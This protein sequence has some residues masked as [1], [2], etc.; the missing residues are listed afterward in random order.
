MRST[1][2]VT[3]S[4]L[5]ALAACGS[6]DPQPTQGTVNPTS[7]RGSIDGVDQVVAAMASGDATS[8]AGGVMALTAAGQSVLVPASASATPRLGELPSHWGRPIAQSFTGSATCTATSCTFTDFGDDSQYGS[9]RLNG[10]ITRSGNHLAFDL[11]FDVTT[12]TVTGHWELD[13]ALDITPTSI[14]GDVHGHGSVSATT[15]QGNCS[16]TWDVDV[17]YDSIGLD[18]SGC[19]TSGSLSASVSYTA[20]SAQGGGSF[21]AAGTI[22]FGPSCGQIH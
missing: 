12:A 16:A 22:A 20:N 2:F 10:S 11:A 3:T 21:N 9:Y 7:A 6:D 17:A 18:G 15:Q 14:D 8:A 4:I 19:P 1:S 13:G 5:L